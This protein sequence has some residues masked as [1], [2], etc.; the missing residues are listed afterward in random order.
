MKLLFFKILKILLLLLLVLSVFAL[1]AG[2]LIWAGWPLWILFFVAAGFL[3]IILGVILIKKIMARKQEQRFVQ[4]IIFQ[5]DATLNRM[6]QQEQNAT[7]EMQKKW[8]EAMDALKR[9]HLK[10]RGNPLYVLPW[11]M[12]I[13]TSGSGKTTAIKSARLTSSFE[14][15]EAISGLS[16]TKNCDWWFFEQA[17]IIDTAG[18]YAVP[19]DETRD[20][21]EWQRFL[22]L[23]ARYRKKEPLN[24]LIITIPADTLN[25]MNLEGIDGY[26]KGIR[27]RIDEIMRVLGSKFPV[28]AMVTKCDLVQGM[29]K[30]CDNLPDESL[31]QTMGEVN[32]EPD[33]EPQIFVTQCFESLGQRIRDIIF[34]ILQARQGKTKDPDLLL[35]PKEFDKLKPGLERFITR[36]FQ[37]TPYQE[38]PLF[39]GIFFTSGRQ[40]GTP[41]SH[42]LKDLGLISEQQM[43]P[44]TSKGLFLHDFFA[45]LLP[46]D[47]GLFTLTARGA[48]WL[49]LTKSL[50]FASFVA[51]VIAFCGLL[52]F[53]FVKNLN[54]LK[55]VTSEF[56]TPGILQGELLADTI[57]LERFNNSILD[58]EKQNQ[59]WWIPRFGLTESLDVETRLK[60]K[61]CTLV[62]SRFIDPLDKKRADTMAYYT[63]SP[64]ENRSRIDNMV[65]L[66]RRI[67]LIRA[68]LSGETMEALSQRPQPDYRGVDLNLGQAV[69][70]EVRQKLKHLYLYT[71]IW[72]T[73]TQEL[74]MEMNDLQ[75]WLVRILTLEGTSMNW[76]ADWANSQEAL[77]AYTMD[78]FWGGKPLKDDKA[79]NVQPAFTLKGK[80]SIDG[81]VKEIEEALTDPL[82]IATKKRDFYTWY[83]AKYLNAWHNFIKAFPSGKDRLSTKNQ[84]K[85]LAQTIH[86]PDSPFQMIR[87]TATLELEPFLT[88]KENPQWV[89]LIGELA[90]VENQASLVK[91]R[92]MGNTGLIKTATD[93]LKSKFSVTQT[94]D[95]GSASETMM[96]A[97]KALVDYE[98]ALEALAPMASSTRAAF[99]GA[100]ILYSED[101]STNQS[102]FFKA[103]TSLATL[104]TSVDQSF[105][106]AREIWDLFYG[107]LDLLQE[108]LLRETA[109]EL[110]KVWEKTVLVELSGIQNEVSTESLVMGDKGLATHFIEGDAA[111]FIERNLKKGYHPVKI[112]GK[113]VDFSSSFLTFLTRGKVAVNPSQKEYA[114]K[115]SGSPTNANDEAL[116]QPN[117]T[118]LTLECEGSTTTLENFNYP[119]REVFHWS[120]EKNCELVLKIKV[121]NLVLEKH[122]NGVHG[123]PKFLREFDSGSNTF[124][125]ENFPDQKAAL[126]RM[127]IDYIRVKYQLSG[128]EPVIKL[129]N[130]SPGKIPMEIAPC[131]D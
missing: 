8:K 63:D 18:R 24:G 13:G 14:D 6:G 97:G 115:I 130:A 88:I 52:S 126:K 125:P 12:V 127:K 65:H 83:T 123:F 56:A 70:E 117:A 122:Y 94:M 95:P 93:R 49:R 67:N 84:W 109:C 92:E 68:R 59:N 15:A 11:Y 106:G 96:T 104:K 113:G 23:L 55:Q 46:G 32:P 26:A 77:S 25:T 44:G 61:Y 72:R 41:F 64:T 82:V 74:N 108:F 69:L 110:Q 112:N 54:T 76:L 58:V 53:S 121:S 89:G 90:R 37:K 20:R 85:I 45:S 7:K 2:G 102:P 87:A 30:F 36:V 38:T 73:D 78:A 40:E 111:P 62:R 4:Q 47:R 33:L 9:S 50:G 43:L 91:A 29:T 3:G 75:K 107:P 124:Y 128:Q 103:Q 129:L 118:I 21:E 101:P 57:A 66:A 48:Q 120:L 119:V 60:E 27:M 100:T 28:Y 71:L 1:I 17:I 39:R 31:K 19:V 16:G 99:N 131:W 42:F 79:V 34:L 5:D 35:F 86:K 105:E 98:R 116:F 51:I 80:E 10:S 22:S 114:V 81:L